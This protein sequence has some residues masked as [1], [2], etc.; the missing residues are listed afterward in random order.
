MHGDEYLVD[1]PE[2]KRR[3]KE[4]CH[5]LL[6]LRTVEKLGLVLDD[7][8]TP[9]E[10]TA[11]PRR[12]AIAQ[13]LLQRRQQKEI[14]AKLGCSNNT[15]THVSNILREGGEGYRLLWDQVRTSLFP[16]ES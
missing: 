14:K 9:E 7:L 16:G 8:L 5:A 6:Q 15:I 10:L 1:N 3:L 11:I 13:E 12:W 4:L 2:T